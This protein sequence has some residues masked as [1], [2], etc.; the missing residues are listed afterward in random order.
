MALNGG[1][2]ERTLQRTGGPGLVMKLNK[3]P[4]IGCFQCAN[5]NIYPGPLN[6]DWICIYI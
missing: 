5:C 4:V 2:V 6:T 3:Y 1:K